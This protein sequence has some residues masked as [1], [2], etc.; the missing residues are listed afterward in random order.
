MNTTIILALASAALGLTAMAQSNKGEDKTK[1]SIIHYEDNEIQVHDTIVDSESGYTAEQFIQA[2]GFHAEKVE[3]IHTQGY[4]GKVS[5]P[6]K[7]EVWF[8]NGKVLTENY[9]FEEVSDN[10][11]REKTFMKKF[12]IEGS[13]NADGKSQKK[14]VLIDSSGELM[15]G[16]SAGTNR[17]FQ[18]KSPNFEI[19]VDSLPVKIKGISTNGTSQ[20]VEVK[21]TINDDGDEETRVWIDGK[22]V[23]HTIKG[24][25][26]DMYEFPK[27]QDSLKEFKPSEMMISHDVFTTTDYSA[28]TEPY[29]ALFNRSADMAYGKPFTI[30][31]VTPLNSRTDEPEEPAA[32]NNG[33]DQIDNL[34]F[35]P[36]PNEGKFRLSFNVRQEGRTSVRIYSIEGKE[37]Y[38]EELGRFSGV[39]EKEID[40]S[41]LAPGTYILHIVKN[42]NTVAEKLIVQ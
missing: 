13:P 33:N 8:M 14:I 31:L 4:H 32:V 12:V 22:E 5:H 35:F 1:I 29:L 7:P 42:K 27:G 37:V 21:K 19:N 39:Y 16:D 24:R 6:V 2:K 18:L 23:S 20:K 28:T 34:H 36:N 10:P 26:E 30:A 40:I 41:N 15:P 9:S 17:T 38:T 11:S 3:I 25:G